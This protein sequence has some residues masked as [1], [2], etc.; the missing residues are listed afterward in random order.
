MM[1]RAPRPR[2][3]FV[4][5]WSV[6]AAALALMIAGALVA[7]AAPTVTERAGA[8]ANAIAPAATGPSSELDDFN[9]PIKAT[10]KEAKLSHANSENHKTMEITV[11]D[12]QGNPPANIHYGV[13][14][15]AKPQGAAEPIDDV[16]NC[17]EQYYND[18]DVPIGVYHCTIIIEGPGAWTFDAAVNAGDGTQRNLEN[19]STTIR[20]SDAV[21]LSGEDKGLLY[22]VE[23][24]AFEVFLLQ[25]HLIV[26][27]LWILISLTMAF[28]AVPRLRRML[29]VLALHTIEVRR[30]FLTSSL[31]G[32]FLV[33]LGTGLYLLA[34]QTAYTAPF[35]TSNF[36]FSDWS[37]ITALPYA[38]TYFTALYT[39]ILLFFVMAAASVVLVM[40]A[41]R[42]A[43]SAQDANPL[44]RDDDDDMWSHGVHFDEEGHVL[45]DEDRDVAGQAAE[46]AVTGTAVKARPRTSEAVGVGPG[47]LWACVAVILGGTA[48]IGVCVTILKYTH[49]LIETAV[50]DTI[51]QGFGL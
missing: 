1:S 44:E 15:T 50:A 9:D 22:V 28:L 30:G 18:P 5:G 19:V 25:L 41:G 17:Q 14:L 33:T 29:S 16:E 27:S 43:Q 3:I 24:S 46:G 23:G 21:Q 7:S 47:V 4:R 13:F 26:A 39:K 40:E 36:S 6:F 34:G 8:A 20:Y 32:T 42:Q 31:W 48:V 2:T 45:H 49:E 10:I 35:S 11:T 12:P 38:Q 37:D 51:L